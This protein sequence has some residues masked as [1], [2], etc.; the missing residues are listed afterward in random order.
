MKTLYCK[1][2]NKV[3]YHRVIKGTFSHGLL[4]VIFECEMLVRSQFMDV[5][6]GFEHQS[7]R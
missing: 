4:L 3:K 6:T 2:K 7:Y 1:Y 5:S